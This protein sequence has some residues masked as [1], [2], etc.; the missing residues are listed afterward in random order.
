MPIPLELALFG[1]ESGAKH[2]TSGWS[3]LDQDS[4]GDRVRRHRRAADPVDQPRLLGAGHRRDRPRAPADLAFLSAHDDDPFARYEA[5]QQLML[6]TL[7]A[8][9]RSGERAIIEPVVEAV[10]NTL[11]RS[12]ARSGLHRRGGAAAD[13]KASSA[14]RWTMVDPE[15]IHAARER[16]ARAARRASSSRSWRAAYAATAANRFELSPAAKGA[17]RLRTVALGYLMAAGA[18]DAPGAGAA[19]VRRA[20][21]T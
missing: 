11:D 12:R 2:A 9:D 17:R 15:A 18:A 21:T 10:R 5:M 4:A 14:T 6:D 3:L 8:R 19:P 13:A 7:L 1:A 16:L 20:P